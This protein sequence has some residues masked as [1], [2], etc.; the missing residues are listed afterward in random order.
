MRHHYTQEECDFLRANISSNSYRELQSMF[1]TKFNCDVTKSAIEHKCKKLNIDHGHSGV[2]L[3]KGESN[4]FSPTHPVGS[5]MVCAGKVYIKVDCNYVPK[6]NSRFGDNGNWVQKNRYVY[7][8]AHGKIPDGYLL[9]A[10]DGNRNNFDP[11]N[12]YAVPRKIG[13]ILGANKWFFADRAV[14]LA[15]IKWCELYY[16]MREGGENGEIR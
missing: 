6:G 3:K 16:A 5:E 14:T 2:V 4:Q 7:E 10:L 15:A 13:M 9:I 12:F 1:N 11:D 8:Q